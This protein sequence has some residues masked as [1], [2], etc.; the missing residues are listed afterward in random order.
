MD[1]ALA[2]LVNRLAARQ[3]AGVTPALR[4]RILALY[5]DPDAPVATKADRKDWQEL[6]VNLAALRAQRQTPS[7]GATVKSDGR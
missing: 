7:A 3:F 6:T 1:E 2:D 4:A 5:A